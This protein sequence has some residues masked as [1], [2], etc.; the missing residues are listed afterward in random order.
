MD[1]AKKTYVLDT[2]ALVNKPNLIESLENSN[3][4]IPIEVLEELD[5]LKVKTDHVGTSARYVNRYLDQIRKQGDLTTGVELNNNQTVMISFK[6]DVSLVK[7]E[8]TVD[9]KI[10]SVAMHCKNEGFEDVTILTRDIAF[11]IKAN[12][13]GINADDVETDKLKNFEE[14]TGIHSIGA[15]AMEVD[16]LYRDGVL[17]IDDVEFYP[18]E[19]VLLKSNQASCLA[20]AHD[21][22]T[23]KKMKIT[24]PRDFNVAGL[25]PRNAEQYFACEFLL[26]QNIDLV[27]LSGMAGTGKTILAVAAAMEQLH[28]G[29]YKK[30]VITRPTQSMSKD[31]GFLPGTLQEKMAPWIQPIMD[32]LEFIYSKHGKKYIEAM[33]EKGD[34]EIA[35]LSHIR[36]RTLPN[37]IFLIDEAQNITYDEAKAI[38]TRMGDKS[39]LILTGDLEQIDTPHLTSLNSGL[40]AIVNLFK[41]YEGAAHVTM[42]KG[43]RSALAT[44]AAK[45]M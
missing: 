15:S 27:T 21:S 22:R 31:I 14:Y 2:S 10:I 16:T 40:A 9:N 33:L 39:K 29:A 44:F 25:R 42:T 43:E 19:G 32:N 24:A 28:S 5:R 35:S 1:I 8:D 37:T 4:I 20:V 26:D 38:L 6:S 17:I 36:G 3:I 18:N 30:L 45:N 7:M 12:A 41:D 34:I 13:V 23:I 11:R